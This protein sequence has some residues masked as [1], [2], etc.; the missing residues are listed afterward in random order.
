MYIS[1]ILPTFNSEKHIG[2]TI[3]SVLTQ[4][5]SEFELIIID[6]G[7]TDKTLN[8]ITEFSEFDSR[9]KIVKVGQNSGCP[10]APRNIG[11]QTSKY[12]WISF[13]DSD[14]I[15]HSKKLEKQI[16][17]IKTNPDILFISTEIINFR[18]LSRLK[19]PKNINDDK[20]IKFRNLLFK[21]R[22]P[23]ST[24]MVSKS[25]FAIQYFNEDIKYKARED[26][27]LWLKFHENIRYSYKIGMKLVAYRLS[28][29]QISG[30]KFTMVKRH[31]NVL[32]NYQLNNNFKLKYF[33]IIFTTTHFI[34]AFLDRLIKRSV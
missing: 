18:D 31:Y 15:W 6:D 3:K 26:L 8:I 9:I 17:I 2:E 29:N 1:I 25:L 20:L 28:D 34:I 33:S 10:A 23:T 27:D 11:V 22:T 13:I 4:T 7:S 19:W 16:E 21:F 14:D 32:Y 5:H 30:N 24:V 12:N